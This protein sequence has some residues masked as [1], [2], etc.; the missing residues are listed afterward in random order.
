MMTEI[1]KKANPLATLTLSGG[2][3]GA[4]GAVPAAYVTNN[5]VVV[6]NP[7]LSAYGLYGTSSKNYTGKYTE[8]IVEGESLSEILGYSWLKNML[9]QADT[10]ILVEPY[11]ENASAKDRHVMR[12]VKASR[13]KEKS[14]EEIL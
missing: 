6:F 8:I 11:S 7:A 2:S 12:G 13:E 14:E 5:D 3:K 10:T 1:L 9:S 4:T